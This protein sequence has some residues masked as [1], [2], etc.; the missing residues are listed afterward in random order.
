MLRLLII[1]LAA[2][3]MPGHAAGADHSGFRAG[4]VRYQVSDVA[5]AITFY[6][7]RLGFHL[8]RQPAPAFAAIA[9][10]DLTLWLSGPGS[11]GARPMPD[12][13]PQTPGGS[14]R[15]VLEVDDLDRTVA[16][17][18]QDGMQFRNAIESGPGGRQIQ[19]NDPDG[20]PI[21]LF[22]PAAVRPPAE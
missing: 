10:G 1:C 5:R 19:L 13:S 4:A 20:N 18:R 14:N 2:T 12:G 11:S 16:A 17:L 3:A 6:T 9:N 21:E 22:E 15:I 8:T 7:E